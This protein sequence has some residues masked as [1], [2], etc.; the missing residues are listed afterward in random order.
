MKQKFLML[1]IIF[2]GSWAWA[3][4]KTYEKTFEVDPGADFYLSSHK[5]TIKINTDNGH[6]VRISARIYVEAGEDDR[7]IEYTEIEA[8]AS[9]NYVRIKVDYHQ[10]DWKS[11]WSGLVGN[12]VQLPF[13]D[14]EITLPNDLNLSLNSHKS[15]FEVN[16]PAG[17][18]RIESHKGTGYIR[19]VR[20][21]LILESHKG[22][23]DVEILEM[24]D[25]RVDTH[26]GEMN[27]RIQGAQDFT[28]LGSTH[29][30]DLIVHGRDVSYKSDEKG[31]DLRLHERFGKGTH[32][33]TLDTHKGTI[34]LNFVD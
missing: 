30:G 12:E 29:K 27:F 24:R 17:E 21:N 7:A 14:F 18:V 3:F 34:E 10:K 33:I 20:N 26:K 15:Q 1:A 25:I 6:T 11:L 2:L 16:A 13:I 9:R 23:F 5:G 8:D 19:Q 28:L 22:A 31:K 4:E 32:R